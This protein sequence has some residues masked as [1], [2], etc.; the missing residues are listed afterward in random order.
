MWSV[1]SCYAAS[2][3]EMLSQVQLRWGEE[4]R[5]GQVCGE[6]ILA[7]HPQTCTCTKGL[8]FHKMEKCSV[9]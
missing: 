9:L 1:R 2:S 5:E 7:R 6:C 8:K 3:N 4:F